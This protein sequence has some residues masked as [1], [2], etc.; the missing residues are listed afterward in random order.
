MDPSQLLAAVEVGSY[1]S[2]WKA[3]IALLVLLI[4]ARLLTWMDKDADRAHLPRVPLNTGMLLGLVLG[5]VFFFLLPGFGL[6]LTVLLAMLALEVGIYLALRN[7]KVGLKDLGRELQEFFSAP[8]SRL[9]RDRPVE[10]AAGEV[11][12]FNY[13][14]APVMQPDAESPDLP[15]FTALQN[16]L[17]GPLKVNAE[18]I[19]LTAA[20][21]GVAVRYIVDGVAYDGTPL[22]RAAGAAAVTFAKQLANLDTS[23]RRRPQSGLIKAQFD[24]QKKAM[25]VATAG[26]KLGESMRIVVDPAH[27]HDFRVETI[28]FTEDQIQMID[29]LVREPGGVVL[30]STPRGQ[31]LNSLLYALVR[32]HDAFL[33]N[34]ATI[35]REKLL[36][37]EG[38][39]QNILPSPAGPAEELKAVDWVVSQEPDVIMIPQ[40]ENPRSAVALIQSAANGKRAYVGLRA[41]STID[42]IRQWRRIVGDDKAAM[43]QLRFVING[44]V[45]RKLCAACKV[46]Y[47]PDPETLRKMNM[48]PEKVGKLYQARTQPLRDQRG[49]PIVCSFCNDLRFKGRT[50]VFELFPVDEEVKQVVLGGGGDQQLKQVFRKKRGRYLQE[51]ALLLVEAGETSVQEVLRALRIGD[52]PAKPASSGA[53]T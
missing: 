13:K 50:G 19:E 52:T 30:V 34:I 1:I 21:E 42:A 38:I 3:L 20:E 5:V 36:D 22:D 23:D 12:L 14:G 18:Q 47:T 35:E 11:L 46:A 17:A 33:T 26:T 45:V 39:T 25:Q 27:R 48:S 53:R 31:G 28:G 7:Q 4:W 32:R 44:R 9:S 24:G 29:D 15:G 40:L 16:L 41:S 10:A 2:L 43:K 8:F 37:L 6:A 49:N 51:Q